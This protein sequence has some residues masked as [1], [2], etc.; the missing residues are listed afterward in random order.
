MGKIYIIQAVQGE[1]ISHELSNTV[2]WIFVAIAM[3]VAITLYVLRSIGIY[4]LATRNGVKK[5][6]LAWVPGL[7][8][9]PV[10]MLIG[11][12][13]FFGKSFRKLAIWFAVIM[14]VLVGFNLLLVVITYLPLGAYYFSGGDV[15]VTTNVSIDTSVSNVFE[16]YLFLGNVYISNLPEL[17]YPFINIVLP[18]YKTVSWLTSILGIAEAIITLNVYLTLFRKFLPNMYIVAGIVSFFGLFPIFVFVARKNRPLDYA[19]FVRAKYARYY[20]AQ[21]NYQQEDYRSSKEK[22]PFEDYPN[23]QPKHK[24]EDPF[25][26]FSDKK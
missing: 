25:E 21:N 20:T 6:G 19:S 24:P 13:G 9:Y 2:F 16:E 1:A 15:F 5:A 23:E 4:T 26:E 7:W 22:S 14:G 17:K 18:I 11:E 3:L 10:C 12:F 8:I